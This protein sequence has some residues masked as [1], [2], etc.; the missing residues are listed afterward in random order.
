MGVFDDDKYFEKP[1]A[2]G[3]KSTFADAKYYAG[4][5]PYNP[6]AEAGR[7][8]GLTTR[9]GVSGLLGLPALAADALVS[10]P[11]MLGA[12]LPI[13]SQEQLR[14]LDRVF[15]SPANTTER[16]AQGIASGMAGAG[17]VVG[18]GR[19][20]MAGPM[21]YAGQE[22]A[23]NVGAQVV[24]GAAA[25]AGAEGAKEMDAGPMTQLGA[26]M[27]AGT[28]APSSGTLAKATG[29]AASMPF[30][31]SGREKIVGDIL[32][33]L[34]LNPE[35]AVQNLDSPQTFVRGSIPTTAQASGDLG[36]LAAET[37]VR[38]LPGA[39]GKFGQRIMNNNEA[40]QSLLGKVAMDKDEADNLR[41]LR[42]AVTGT[43]RD[44]AFD[45]AGPVT[46]QPVVDTIDL[47]SA[48][49]GNNREV[50]QK[51]LGWARGRV[52]S[53]SDDVNSLYAVRKDIRDVMSSDAGRL[54]KEMPDYRQARG[55]LETVLRAIDEQIEAV[56]PGFMDYKR[57]FAR[58][59]RGIDRGELLGGLRTR[60]ETNASNP[61]TGTNV[62]GVRFSEAVRKQRDTLAEQLTPAQMRIVES[63]ADDIARGSAATTGAIRPPG[64][65][66]FKNLS[67]AEF[68]GRI[69][70]GHVS[71]ETRL[72]P[73]I[74]K[75]RW[76]YSI[77]DDKMNDLLVDAMLDP[78]MARR[79]MQQANA[80]T[81]PRLAD[82]L[83]R[84]A[85]NKGLVQG[86]SQPTNRP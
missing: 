21:N 23:S 45:N 12:N 13:P 7:Q 79:L 60:F 54:N 6:V 59:S 30:S 43:M 69:V 66:T 81:L 47:L 42:K 78:S 70:G 67:T 85:A 68:I 39:T 52:L 31:A 61:E 84:A 2:K 41:S 57:A 4:E 51:A 64:S 37:T 53:S 10:I 38:G 17:G 76:L 62:L 29:R 15:P 71:K 3:S 63:I 83:K 11:N 8:I 16:M 33:R 20:L 27:L 9:A 32:N 48:S 40:R 28:V 56:A 86:T 75:F 46:T 82:D 73:V 77:P 34:A 1:S 22:M 24:G 25:S 18:L 50:V 49:P 58:F 14:L 44:A 74:D 55:E 80:M 36:L 5:E 19:G 65:D 26:A 35:R 72:Q